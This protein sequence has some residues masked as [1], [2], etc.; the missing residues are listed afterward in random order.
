M[1][2]FS[3]KSRKNL[4]RL[5]YE[6]HKFEGWRLTITR[7]GSTFSR[8]YPDLKFGNAKKSLKAAEADLV[9]LKDVLESSKLI[10]GRLTSKTIKSAEHILFKS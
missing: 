6:R 2:V 5:S 8:Y 7:R 10:N 4:T 9:E 1:L 3:V